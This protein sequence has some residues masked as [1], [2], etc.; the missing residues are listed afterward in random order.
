MFVFEVLLI[1]LFNNL[2]IWESEDWVGG[3]HTFIALTLYIILAWIPEPV[4][5]LTIHI[6]FAIKLGKW[7]Q[8]I[9]CCSSLNY[10]NIIATVVLAVT[11]TGDMEIIYCF[12]IA[13]T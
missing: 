13:N 5:I 4:K 11:I 10:N 2:R 3:F 12:E 1:T 7:G 6:I 9:E 8:L